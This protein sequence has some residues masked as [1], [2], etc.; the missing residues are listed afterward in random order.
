MGIFGFPI[1]SFNSIGGYAYIIVLLVIVG[2][3]FVWGFNQL[4]NSALPK[5]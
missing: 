3:A 1:A 5:K 4:N 2:G